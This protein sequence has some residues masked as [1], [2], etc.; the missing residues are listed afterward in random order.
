M[1]RL[2]Q[3]GHPE[4]NMTIG[5][6]AAVPS[7]SPLH[8]ASVHPLSHG[9]AAMSYNIVACPRTMYLYTLCLS[10]ILPNKLFRIWCTVWCKINIVI[11]IIIILI[12]MF[13]QHELPTPLTPLAFKHLK[14]FHWVVQVVKAAIQFHGKRA[15]VISLFK[16]RAA[17]TKHI[18][19][20]VKPHWGGK[21]RY[22]NKY[23]PYLMFIF[24][25]VSSSR[26]LYT[27]L[28]L[29]PALCSCFLVQWLQLQREASSHQLDWGIF[30]LIKICCK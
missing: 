13:R 22:N 16:T 4:Q 6:F 10:Y 7:S 30:L 21:S 17:V 2:I 28:L 25:S 26:V 27:L 20:M 18:K 5:S 29:C 12:T 11:I 19:H 15:A 24:T 1:K 3:V 14:V 8:Q 9:T 23:V